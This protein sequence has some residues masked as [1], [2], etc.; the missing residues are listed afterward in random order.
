MSVVQSIQ[1][2]LT[3]SNP[4]AVAQD[5]LARSD[6]LMY[7]IARHKSEQNLQYN[8][9]FLNL[10]VPVDDLLQSLVTWKARFPGTER[11]LN[12]L[13]YGMPGSGKTAFAHHLADYLGLNPIVKRGSDLMSP[14]VGMTEKAIHEAFHEA[15]GSVLIIDEADSLLSERQTAAH[16]WERS[17]T[18]EILTSMESFKGLFIASTNFKTALDSASFRRFTFKIEF[19][20]TLPE[21]RLELISTYFPELKWSKEDQ[22]K[23]ENISR[24]YSR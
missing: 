3:E 6:E 24:Y 20:S 2:L 12:L 13:F 16:R 8:A 9:R 18:N 21:R 10:G 19:R 14:Y 11:G 23:L 7:G 1:L 15:E 5:M 4:F 17:Q 22:V